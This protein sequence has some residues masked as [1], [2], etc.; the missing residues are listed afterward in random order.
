MSD[1]I[2]LAA[3][4]VAQ[5][6][7]LIITAGAGMGVDS[8]LPD[9]RGNKGFWNAYPLYERLG[10]DYVRIANP[11]HFRKDPAFSW[12]FSGHCED[13]YRRTVPHLG[14][15]LILDWIKRYQLDY[16]VETSNVD[17]HF[18][19]AGFA[20]EKVLEIH[21][22]HSHLQCLE[23]CAG[24]IWENQE[25]VP[26]DLSTMRAKRIPKCPICKGIA[27]PNVLMF[28]DVGWVADRTNAQ[29]ERYA[30]FLET[31]EGKNIVVIE[32]GAGTL[33]ASIR[34]GSESLAHYY[35]A[36]VIRINPKQ[37]FIPEP[38]IG[39]KGGALEMLLNMEMHL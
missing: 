17:G 21:G 8:G 6:D 16:F 27:R 34:H 1:K 22:A 29:K 33:I 18:Q 14:F 19:K 38:H 3:T 39:L 23:N 4:W 5:S 7:V 12:G 30:D 20:E 9:Y 31:N 24:H 25:V 10:I 15:Q 37:P 13:L 11:A 26:V 35:G 36:K 2:Q 28:G 32:M